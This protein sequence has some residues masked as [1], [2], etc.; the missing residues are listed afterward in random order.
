MPLYLL[1]NKNDNGETYEIQY[2]S[3]ALQEMCIRFINV[4]GLKHKHECEFKVS[5]AFFVV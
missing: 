2:F 5:L 3:F 1:Y 4:C